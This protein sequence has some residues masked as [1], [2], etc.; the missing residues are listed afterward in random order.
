M[1]GLSEGFDAQKKNK[2]LSSAEAPGCKVYDNYPDSEKKLV[3][4]KKMCSNVQLSQY[5]LHV[6]EQSDKRKLDS[7]VKM[8][9]FFRLVSPQV[10]KFLCDF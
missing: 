5:I 4:S 2:N 7:G 10:C 6:L 9:K 1:F 8:I 3:F